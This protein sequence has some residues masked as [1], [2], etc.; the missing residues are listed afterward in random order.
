VT[1]P[2]RNRTIVLVLLG[3]AALTALLVFGGIAL[4][5]GDD[6]PTGW[7]AAS[8]PYTASSE[9]PLDGG[10][11]C[12]RATLS[13]TLTYQRSQ[14]SDP[15]DRHFRRPVLQG[16]AMVVASRVACTPGA[17]PKPAD[18]AGLTQQWATDDGTPM[19]RVTSSYDAGA[20]WSQQNSGAPLQA[21]GDVETTG[22]L[23]VVGTP[24]VTLDGS[25]RHRM[26]K[27]TVCGT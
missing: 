5:G 26:P 10:A 1:E 13:G 11:G 21:E 8:T 3:V 18:S 19:G 27:V 6:A 7:K 20:D 14:A 23:C 2:S 22:K 17:D 9:L 25:Q 4:L 15:A 12:L 16:A 24:V